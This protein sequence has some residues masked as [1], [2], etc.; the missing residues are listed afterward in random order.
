MTKLRRWH[1]MKKRDG[2][3]P[4]ASESGG[5]PATGKSEAGPDRQ[6]E[7]RHRKKPFP[8]VT[9]SAAIKKAMST[10]AMKRRLDAIPIAKE[11]EAVVGESVAQHVQPTA[12]EKGILTIEADSSAWRHQISLERDDLWQKISARFDRDLVK[13]IRI[14]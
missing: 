7:K 3:V 5:L 14:K 4:P 9:L 10:P 6:R 13:G 12:L 11:W 2:A 8:F 1:S